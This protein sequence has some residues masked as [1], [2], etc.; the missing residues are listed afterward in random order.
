MGRERHPV[1]ELVQDPQTSDSWATKIFGCKLSRRTSC[2]VPERL[3]PTRKSGLVIAIVR[4]F[5]Q[6]S[7]C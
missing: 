3:L 6:E 4:L 2:D 7:A 1:V 5:Y